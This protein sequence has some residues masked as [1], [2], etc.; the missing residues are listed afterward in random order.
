MSEKRSI[1]SRARITAIGSYVPERTLTNDDLEKMVDTSD[2]WIV[3]RTGIRERRIAGSDV[4]TSDLCIEAVRNM[5]SEYQAST[6]DIDMILVATSTSDF[7]FPSVACQIQEQFGIPSA[8]TL[9]LSA[10]CAGFVYGLN[11]A[12]ALVTSG[13]HRKV[14]V[15]GGETLSKVTDYTDRTTCILFG[16]AAG[17]AL[18]ERDENNPGFIHSCSGSDGRAGIHLYRTGLSGRMKGKV[19]SGD[20]NIVQ[21]GREVFKIAVSTLTREVPRLL[22]NAGISPDEVDWFIPHSANIRIIQAVCERI[23]FPMEKTLFSA[24]YYGNT[25]SATIPLAL[26]QGVLEGKIKKGD[27][28]LLYG[29]GGGFTHAGTLVRWTI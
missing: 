15:V 5:I 21:N 2:E 25:S 27:T 7:P 22:E 1:T 18:V 3:P 11:M 13:L 14:L 19:L 23:G 12:D 6:D 17:A 28:L 20:G 26:H 16:D 29:F 9:D 24:E 4:F 10:A 8:G